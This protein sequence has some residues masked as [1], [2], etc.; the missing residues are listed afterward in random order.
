[1]SFFKKIGDLFNPPGPRRAP[2]FATWITVKCNRCGELIRVRIDLRNDLSIDYGEGSGAT[3]HCHKVLVGEQRCFQKIDVDL[4]FDARHKL[5]DRQI[6][7][8]EFVDN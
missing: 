2:D 3:Y 6:S 4:T 5:T 1:M 8:G 7:G